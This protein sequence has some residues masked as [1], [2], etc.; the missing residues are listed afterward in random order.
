M[1]KSVRFVMFRFVLAAL[2]IGLMAAPAFAVDS[3]YTKTKYPIILVAGVTGF[4]SLFGTLD[5]WYGM[6][7]DLRKGGA[8]VIS[9][10]LTGWNGDYEGDV[11]PGHD[12][13]G[14]RG[15]ELEK[16]I[17]DFMDGN[18]QWSQKFEKVN[19]I[20]HSQGATTSRYFLN[21]HADK[22]ASLTTIAGPHKGTAVADYA[23]EKISA[24]V[25]N[26]LAAGI[27][28]LL[29]DLVALS[30]GNNHL[31]GTQDTFQT[32]NHFRTEG[33][34]RFNRDFPCPALPHKVVNG[35]KV[36]NEGLQGGYG[37]NLP[38]G[39][40]S[41]T[42]PGFSNTVYFFS[43]SGNLGHGAVTN[44]FD[45]LDLTA[46]TLTNWFNESYNYQGAADGFVPASSA[47]FG[48]VLST[49]YQWNHGDEINQTLGI[50]NPWAA[51]PKTVIC[52]HANRLKNLNL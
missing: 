35:Q 41:G 52:T 22:V 28:L 49:S 23:W 25:Q 33:I 46:W 13:S 7:S 36:Y 32:L 21:R 4:D 40:P 48:K 15:P 14:L 50:R 51:N 5:Y 42:M 1:G 43:W 27:N 45:P 37:A 34:A 31:I 9:V 16:I 10:A 26:V 6:E 38:D 2:F 44:I 24:G 20:A 17:L 3:T 30:S 18:N 11:L 8:K 29:G 12:S 39:A 19:I 47:R